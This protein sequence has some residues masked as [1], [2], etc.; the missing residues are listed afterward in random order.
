MEPEVS[1]PCSQEPPPPPPPHRKQNNPLFFTW[2]GVDQSQRLW[3][4]RTSLRR[5]R[6]ES[7]GGIKPLESY[8]TQPDLV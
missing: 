5:K 7:R 1:L 6:F 4:V 8:V 2:G 3:V